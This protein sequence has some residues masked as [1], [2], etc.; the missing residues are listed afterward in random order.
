MN[1]YYNFSVLELLGHELR[2]KRNGNALKTVLF[3]NISEVFFTSIASFQ[4]IKS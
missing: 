3:C 1:L 2:T 4:H